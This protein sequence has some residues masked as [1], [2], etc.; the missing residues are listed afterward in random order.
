[1]YFNPKVA[2]CIPTYEKPELLE[3][4]LDSIEKQNY[5]NYIIIVTDNSETNSIEDIIEKINNLKIC[6]WHNEHQLGATGNTN[7]AIDKA[8]EIGAE[9]IKIMYQD[10]WFSEK[11]SLKK[12]VEKLMSEKLDIVFTGSW[13]VYNSYTTE[14]ICSYDEIRKIEEDEGV[15]FRANLLGAPSGM[16]FKPC[17]CRLDITY[18]WLLDVDFY[19]RLLKGKKWGYIYE[20]LIS[21]GHDGEQL[22]D[23]YSQNPLL[24][25]KETSRQYRKYKWLHTFPNRVYILKKTWECIKCYLKFWG[26][27]KSKK[28]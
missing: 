6:Y 21:I 28:G 25:L 20:S 4:L 19:L 8:V 13:E 12:M 15:L 9:L 27:G 3:R 1:M 5:D 16:L 7:K 24:I 2:I 18:T 23:Y 26:N 14:R 22:T 17:D 11:E 10:D